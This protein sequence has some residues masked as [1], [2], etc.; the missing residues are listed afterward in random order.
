MSGKKAQLATQ[1]LVV[2]ALKE[3]IYI[4]CV[5]PCDRSIENHHLMLP[6]DDQKCRP[7]AQNEVA[8]EAFAGCGYID[9]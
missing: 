4:I 1:E 3:E 2:Q 7:I 9:L 5:A 6:F 8:E